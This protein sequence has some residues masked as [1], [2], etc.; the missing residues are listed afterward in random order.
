LVGHDDLPAALSPGEELTLRLVWDAVQPPDGDYTMFAHLLDE[1]GAI[2][3]QSDRAPED[4]FYPTSQWDAG[5]LVA[6]SYTL[7]L[8]NDLPSGPLQLVVGIYDPVTGQRALL[9]T[10]DDALKIAAW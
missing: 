4:G 2:V 10:G 8:P 5:D 3:A 1:Q 6:D 7:L 9:E